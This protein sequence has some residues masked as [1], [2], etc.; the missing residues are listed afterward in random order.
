[1]M[2]LTMTL[3]QFSYHP[4]NVAALLEAGILP[5]LPHLLG[6]DFRHPLVPVAVELLWNM[7]DLCPAQVRAALAQQQP[8]VA[9]VMAGGAGPQDEIPAVSAAG[10]TSQGSP[11]AMPQG[12]G[13]QQEGA[14]NQVTLQQGATDQQTGEEGGL[15][16]TTDTTLGFTSPKRTISLPTVPGVVLPDLAHALAA[17]IQGTLLEVSRLLQV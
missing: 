17:L 2:S 6:F 4:D 1:M 7:L 5:C 8:S 12:T 3:G 16:G 15:G 9:R 14:G 11:S 13:S 10:A